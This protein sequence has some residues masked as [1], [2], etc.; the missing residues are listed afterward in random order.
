MNPYRENKFHT[1]IIKAILATLAVIFLVDVFFKKDNPNMISFSENSL[2]YYM[3]LFGFCSA[4]YAISALLIY[5][6]GNSE[7]KTSS[8]KF[9]KPKLWET[10]CF[11]LGCLFWVCSLPAAIIFG[12]IRHL[13]DERLTKG[14][15]REINEKWRERYDFTPC[16][17]CGLSREKKPPEP[18]E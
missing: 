12:A 9:Q 10:I 18:W 17:Y 13:Y 1:W 16:P 3:M 14:T 11:Y 2:A 5:L 4:L 15:E 7:F 8:E 6:G